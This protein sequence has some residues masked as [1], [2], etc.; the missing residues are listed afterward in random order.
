MITN[1]LNLVLRRFWKRRLPSIIIILSIGIAISISTLLYTFIQYETRTD[2][3]HS[4]AGF[5]YRLLSNDPFADG[6]KTLSFIKKDASDYV[7]SNFPEIRA[8]CKI[9]ELSGN[10]VAVD[11]GT[12]TYEKVMVLAVDSSFYRM[13]DYPFLKTGKNIGR[14]HVGITITEKLALK[15]FGQVDVLGEELNIQ[16]DTLR[17]LFTVTAVMG[18]TSENTHLNFDALVPFHT[19]DRYLGASTTYLQ[20]DE[21]GLKKDVEAKISNDAQMPSLV[22]PGECDYFLQ[23]L[24]DIYFDKS[25]VR[26]FTVAR[27]VDFIKALWL[28]IFFILFIGAFNFLNLFIIS[29][30]DRRKELGVR[31]IQGASEGNI[32]AAMVFEIFVYLFIGLLVSVAISIICL[33]VV[34]QTFESEIS[35]GYLFKPVILVAMAI[36]FG[37]LILVVS[38]VLTFY[39]NRIQPINLLSE[40][41]TVR[42]NFNKGFFTLQFVISLALILSAVVIIK[43]VQFIKNKP[44]GFERNIIELRLPKEGKVSD[45][46]TLKTKLEQHSVFKNVSLSS[47]NPVSGNQQIRFDLDDKEFYSAYFMEGDD[48]LIKT[49]GLELKAGRGPSL[50]TGKDKVVNEKFVRHF[51]ISDP[52]GAPIP[53]GNGEKIIG[54]VSDFNVSSLKQEIPLY[55][56]GYNEAPSRI[57]INYSGTKLDEVSLTLQ[58][59]WSEMFPNSPFTYSFLGDELLAKHKD[60][61]QF[62]SIVITFSIVSILI[63]CFGLFALAQSSCQK[64]GKEIAIRKSLGASILDVVYMLI[65]DFGKWITVSFAFAAII[66]YFGIQRWMETFAYRTDIDWKVFVLTAAIGMFFFLLAISSQTVRAAKANPIKGLR[67]E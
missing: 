26:K 25:N 38:F 48:N 50:S 66:G 59:Y 36:L 15:I 28:I 60:D 45:L 33:P 31:K 6:D 18:T 10:G 43:Q 4:Q 24:P 22:G 55:M 56:I 41:S 29:L 42:I 5:V 49:L 54:I 35:V 13:F 17:M 52:I 63:S 7:A 46:L 2:R 44:L 23:P 67:H 47:G 20:L 40:K 16:Y 9:T 61:F 53:G 3:F 58:A 37:A 34:N 32:R 1:Q 12:D 21:H 27:N 14:D 57:L 65:I 62:G 19:F 11:H 30:V 8:L 39:L 64:K 51:H